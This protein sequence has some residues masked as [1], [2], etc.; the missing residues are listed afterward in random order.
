[1]GVILSTNRAIRNGARQAPFL[2]QCPRT[3][4]TPVDYASGRSY[5]LEQPLIQAQETLA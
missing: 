5:S 2:L 3:A 1:M 4:S